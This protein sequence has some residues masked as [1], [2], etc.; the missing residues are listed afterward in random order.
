MP[1]TGKLAFR[2]L[3]S[4]VL[5]FLPHTLSQAT[6]SPNNVPPGPVV[7]VGYASFLGNASLPGVEF[8]G[9]I[10]Y[11]QPPLDDLRWRAPE[12]L[13]ETPVADKNITDARHWGSIC[14]QQ[15]AQVGFG[16]ED[17]LTLNVWRSPNTKAGDNLPVAVYIHGG[18]NYYGSA[19][20]FPMNTWITEN[21][22]SIVAVNLQY[23]LGMLGFLASSIV[24]EDGNANVGLLDQR[25]ALN[26]V[27]R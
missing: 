7:D 15:P 18:G 21:D 25:A 8:F 14:I 17:C 12:M 27:R 20:G 23:R 2:A 1:L 5:S 6:F 11:V 9:G 3:A 10:R 4:T 13:N 26:W 24:E 16:S 19:Q 22:G